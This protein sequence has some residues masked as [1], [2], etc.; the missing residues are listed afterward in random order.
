MPRSPSQCLTKFAISRSPSAPGMRL[1]LT[2]L[3]STSEASRLAVGII[4]ESSSSMRPLVRVVG[5]DLFLLHFLA[6]NQHVAD[7]LACGKLF[8]SGLVGP[9]VSCTKPELVVAIPF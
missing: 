3:I 8:R 7:P 9:R 6:Y 1:G 5:F 4:F 2:E